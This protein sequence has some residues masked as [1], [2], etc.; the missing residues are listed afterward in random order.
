MSLPSH[1]CTLS[2][3][4]KST[5]LVTNLSPS[6]QG[7]V[8]A[9]SYIQLADKVSIHLFDASALCFNAD[10][11]FVESQISL[12]QQR[13]IAIG[14]LLKISGKLS[15]IRLIRCQLDDSAKVAV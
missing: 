7:L 15:V 8:C 12:T 5:N 2:T 4:S 9:K 11:S 6:T 14:G 13:D 10:L 3:I 1:I